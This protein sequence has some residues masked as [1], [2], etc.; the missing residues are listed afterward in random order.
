MLTPVSVRSHKRSGGDSPRSNGKRPKKNEVSFFG[1]I[2]LIQ[3]R[4]C[5]ECPFRQIMDAVMVID[6]YEQ[7]L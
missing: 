2:N 1:E 3:C 6:G 7:I 5:G 4:A